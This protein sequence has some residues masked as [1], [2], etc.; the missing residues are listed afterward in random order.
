MRLTIINDQKTLES[1]A[2]IISKKS[3]RAGK[4]DQNRDKTFCIDI[5]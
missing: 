4:M 2:C 5:L 1:G 3:T